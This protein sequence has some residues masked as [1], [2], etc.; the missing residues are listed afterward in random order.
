MQFNSNTK[1]KNMKIKHL[2]AVLTAVILVAG[3]SAPTA[4][5]T[6]DDIVKG[7]ELRVGVQSDVAPMAF[8]DKNGAHTG[9]MIDFAGDMAKRMGVRLKLLQFD[10]K[11]M[12]P[13]LLSGKVDI[14]AADMTATLQRALK[15]AFT[16]PWYYSQLCVFTKTAIIAPYETLAD[17][18]RRGVTVGV[19]QGSTGETMARKIL[20]NASV[21]PFRSDRMII[22]ALLKGGIDAGINDELA[23]LTA[24]PNYPPNSVRLLKKRLGS[25][26]PLCFAVRPESDHLW[27]WVNLYFRT[28]RL[29]GTYDRIIGYWV[30]SG[31]WVR[32]HR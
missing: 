2:V 15:V 26:A 9:A 8:V 7:G 32:D 25:R 28:V 30:K 4:A 23:V 24:L 14:L 18:D 19:L 5:G 6:L 17:V 3:F 29:D 10:W 20:K 13:A 31:Q 11:D 22:D 27:K 16:D 12:I 1:E 21:K